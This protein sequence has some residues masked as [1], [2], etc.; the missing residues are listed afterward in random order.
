MTFDM[1]KDLVIPDMDEL[2]VSE[3]ENLYPIEHIPTDLSD[4]G[5]Y[6]MIKNG[7]ALGRKLKSTVESWRKTEKSVALAYGKK[8]DT[9]AKSFSTRI[10]DIYGPMH[11]AKKDYDTYVE[12]TKREEADAEELRVNTI[13]ERIARI[14]ALPLAHF[15]SSSVIIGYSIKELEENDAE[16]AMEFSDSA[17]EAINNAKENLLQLFDNAVNAEK[18]AEIEA[19]NEAKRK[20]EEAKLAESNRIAAAQLAADR[21]EM[22]AEK[23][24][25]QAEKDKLAAEIKAIANQ[26]AADKQAQ[27]A[28]A[29]R[30]KADLAE[31]LR[32]RDEE[33]KAAVAKKAAEEAETARLKALVDHRKAREKSAVKA[34]FAVLVDGKSK[35]NSTLAADILGAIVAGQVDGV[36]F[37]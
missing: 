25:M 17:E 31:A 28:A 30:L 2:V 12:I 3:F 24:A 23:A 5:N 18:A 36:K 8:I 37:E 9:H 26:K 35:P 6:A 29:A 19:E 33:E 13:N 11:T 32:K 14:K 21:A 7:L 22:E 34:I 16:W 4:K 20:E 10:M 15:K 1:N 27:I